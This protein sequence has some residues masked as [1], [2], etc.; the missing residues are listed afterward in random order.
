MLT[1]RML[2]Q[3]SIQKD[4]LPIS[5]QSRPAQSLLALLM[6]TAG[7]AHRRENLAGALWPNA[8]DSNAR[9]YLR[10]ELWRLN[11]ALQPNAAAGVPFLNINKISIAF[12]AEAPCWLDVRQLL[13][14]GFRIDAPAD[15]DLAV[16]FLYQGVLLPGIYEDWVTPYRAE[17]LAAFDALM[18]RALPR[19]RDLQRYDAV[20]RA[21]L[22]WIAHGEMLETAYRELMLAHHGA[23]D[24]AA[25]RSDMESCI[26]H[27][28]RHSGAKPSRK[29]V[30]L[31]Q[32]LIDE[33]QD[34]A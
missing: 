33:Q 29:T 16:A 20:V 21:S 24:F 9:S 10:H 13:Q 15:D 25:I 28:R 2:G 34:P 3:F 7:V 5:L 14:A 18:Q 4:G 17:A 23:H 31:F 19:L 12:N 30:A 6:L 8:S 22:H 11:R 1:V 32:S 27:L 26:A